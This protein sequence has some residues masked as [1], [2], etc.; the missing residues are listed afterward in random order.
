MGWF[1]DKCLKFVQPYTLEITYGVEN[2]SQ[3]PLYWLY[4]AHILCHY[5]PGIELHL[6]SA[7]YRRDE[8]IGQPLP[9]LCTE[10][11][12]FLRRFEEFP[13]QS[14]A[15]YVS[16]FVGSAGCAYIDR[17][18]RKVLYLRWSLPVAYLA[19][20]YNRNAWMPN[21]PLTHIGLEPTTAGSQ[22]LAQWVRTA[23]PEPLAPG[24]RVAWTLTLS[25]GDLKSDDTPSET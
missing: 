24:H 16:D 7:C 6:P 13:D 5:R 25:A 23:D 12:R 10:Q 21:Q 11:A 3:Y 4:C 18:A 1:F 2:R 8:T 22:D 9:E 20:W 14:A 19:I 15:F 17:A